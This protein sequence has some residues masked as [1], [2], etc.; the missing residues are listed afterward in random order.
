MAR[1]SFSLL[2]TPEGVLTFVPFSLRLVQEVVDGEEEVED[3]EG[4]GKRQFF[5]LFVCLREREY[6]VCCVCCPADPVN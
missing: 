2:L 5:C 1:R 4:E 3:V 6:D